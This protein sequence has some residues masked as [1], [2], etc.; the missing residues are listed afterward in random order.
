MKEIFRGAESVIFQEKE[1]IVKLRLQ[2]SYRVSVIDKKINKSRTRKEAGVLKRIEALNI[3]PKTKKLSE[4]S[5]KYIQEMEQRPEYA[6]EMEYVKGETLTDLW[7]KHKEDTGIEDRLHKLLHEAGKAIALLHTA[8]VVHGDLTLNNIIIQEEECRGK[9]KSKI[10]LIDFGLSQISAKSEDK[11]VDLYLFEKAVKALTG[12]EYG[13][14]IVEGYL[15][16]QKTKKDQDTLQNT[17][18]K[19]KEVR[20]RGR[21]RE[22][23][24]VG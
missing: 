12:T 18:N 7:K 9:S 21:K 19:L 15:S 11:A 13:S 16:E 23:E 5:A 20:K 10:V 4:E 14:T 1:N 24:A 2:K 22:L 6:I 3:S 8:D 17:V